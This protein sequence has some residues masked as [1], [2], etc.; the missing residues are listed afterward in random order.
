M[1]LEANIIQEYCNKGSLYSALESGRL[2]GQNGNGTMPSAK[3]AL[4]IA[5]DVACGMHHIHSLQIIHGDLKAQNV[6]LTA[7]DRSDSGLHFIA[8]VSS[9]SSRPPLVASPRLRS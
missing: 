5:L 1:L 9:S 6:L 2:P 4:Q 3:V 8:K 7:H